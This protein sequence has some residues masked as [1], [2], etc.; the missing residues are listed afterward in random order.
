MAFLTPDL[1]PILLLIG[2]AY[3]LLI[4]LMIVLIVRDRQ[5]SLNTRII[6]LLVVLLVPVIGLLLVGGNR[7]YN[8]LVKKAE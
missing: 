4:S 7:F 6:E 2:G 8:F 5:A 1:Q 3:L